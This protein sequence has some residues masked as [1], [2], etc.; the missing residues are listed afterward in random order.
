MSR[1]NLR[2]HYKSHDSMI[3]NIIAC[4]V[5]RLKRASAKA[6]RTFTK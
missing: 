2:Q 4:A 1:E 5:V 6:V 3:L